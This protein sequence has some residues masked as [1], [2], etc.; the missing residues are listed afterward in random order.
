MEG[1]PSEPFRAKEGF[2]AAGKPFGFFRG[3]QLI[4]LEE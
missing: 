2:K 4:S 1:P 3:L